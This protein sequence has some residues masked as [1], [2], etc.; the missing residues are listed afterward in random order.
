MLY[1]LLSSSQVSLVLSDPALHPQERFL[2]SYVDAQ[3][4]ILQLK[5]LLSSDKDQKYVNAF[6]PCCF[7]SLLKN[8]PKT[9]GFT[10]R[11][12]QGLRRTK[13]GV[14]GYPSHTGG[15]RFDS[16]NLLVFL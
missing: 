15:P 1:M 16:I 12:L 6:L 3:L 5:Q 8:D 13:Y 11:A 9:P 10:Q 4:W 2:K 14:T 7:G